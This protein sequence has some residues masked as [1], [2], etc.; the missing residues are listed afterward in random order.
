MVQTSLSACFTVFLEI[1]IYSAYLHIPFYL[2]FCCCFRRLLFLIVDYLESCVSGDGFVALQFK[3][4]LLT[5]ASY[6]GGQTEVPASYPASCECSC[7]ACE[8][9]H[10][11]GPCPPC[12][13]LFLDHNFSLLQTWLLLI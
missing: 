2:F 5:P 13:Q 11:L 1:L 4:F 9:A 6:I 7:E 8:V 10:A 12:R 3:L